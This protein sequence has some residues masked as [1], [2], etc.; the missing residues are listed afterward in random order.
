MGCSEFFSALAKNNEIVKNVRKSEKLF[1]DEEYVY[2]LEE[3]RYKSCYQQI[4]NVLS[5]KKIDSA[6]KEIREIIKTLIIYDLPIAKAKKE[7]FEHYAISVK[8]QYEKE[9]DNEKKEELLN[10]TSIYYEWFKRWSLIYESLFALVSFRSLE[11]F[12]IFMEWDK[13]PEEKMW[14]YSIDTFGDNGYSGCLKGFFFYANQMVLN[15]KIKF[16][17]KQLP[18]SFGK[19]YSDSEMIAFIL[20]Y[21]KNEQIIKITG[22]NSLPSKCTMQIVKIMASKRYLQVFPEYAQLWDGQG[23]IEKAI[24]SVCQLKDGKLTVMGCTNDTSFECFSK[25][26]KRDGIRGGYLFLDDIVQRKEILNL[27]AH[28]LDLD[29][30][31]GTWKKRSRDEKKF[32]IVCGGTTYDAY[33]LLCELKLRYSGGKLFKTQINKWT[34]I[35]EKQ[36]AIFICVPK[37][38][39]RDRLTFPQKCVLENVLADR[40]NNYELF[41]AMDMQQPMIPKEYSFYWDYLKQYDYVPSDCTEFAQATLDPART[42]QNYVSMPICKIRKELDEQGEEIEIHYLVD[43]LYKKIPME[44]AYTYIC[45]LIE[46]HHI[47]RLHI[48]RNT[49][50]SLAY[51][52]NKMLKEKGI[53]Y[54]E[55]SEVYSTKNKEERIYADENTIKKRFRYPKR[56]MYSQASDMGQFMNHVISYKYKGSAYD[57]S[58]DSLGLYCD[59]FINNKGKIEKAQ[60]LYI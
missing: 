12:A 54:C 5:P 56:D 51:L 1:N 57:D 49:D 22:N 29:D 2:N 30:F 17:L 13:I 42:G 31:D 16:I 37:L 36:D 60:L 53:S 10:K 33:D 7:R 52:L 44:E 48:E 19:T 46:R 18:T 25:D 38:D 15:D 11:H 28:Q 43:C 50:T 35:N 4:H 58:I 27:V 40:R 9:R 6:E 8:A 39:E 47:V 3:T 34:S 59:K 55:I 20:G 32:K 26:C 23:E 41:M 14:E 45:T 21:N 24:Y